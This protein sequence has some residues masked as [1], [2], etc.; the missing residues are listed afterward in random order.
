[1][2]HSKANVKLPFK[3]RDVKVAVQFPVPRDPCRPIMFQVSP[4]AKCFDISRNFY[5]QRF[6]AV[7]CINSLVLYNLSKSSITLRKRN[8]PMVYRLL[9][10]NHMEAA[11]IT[12]PL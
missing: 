4:T 8:M 12:G 3:E 6:N 5:F 1:M 10:T 11:K 2:A 7:C 9:S